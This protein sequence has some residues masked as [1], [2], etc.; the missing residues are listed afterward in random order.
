MTITTSMIMTTSTISPVRSPVRNSRSTQ[1]QDKV[2]LLIVTIR[3]PGYERRVRDKSIL[4]TLADKDRLKVS[5]K[6]IEGKE[7]EAIQK[8]DSTIRSYVKRTA[9]PSP[10]KEGVYA[11][12][13]GL[14]EAV[15]AKLQQFS[16]E[17][18]A[19]VEK[20]KE[21]WSASVEQA[22]G[23]LGNLFQVDDYNI[24]FDRAYRL[25]W[26]YVSLSAPAQIEGI[27]QELYTRE[28]ARLQKQWEEAVVEMRDALRVGLSEL[29]NDLVQRLSGADGEKRVKP[30]RLLERF[31]EFLTSFQARNVTGDEQLEAL[32]TQ[33]RQILA[34]VST[35]R[36][37]ASTNVRK[38]VEQGFKQVQVSLTKLETESRHR[39]I[40]FDDE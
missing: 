39:R 22:R 31:Q 23:K 3:G 15:D 34:G 1:I 33:A 8:L 6:L 30:S 25:E 26:Q 14:L 37:I 16:E 10:F 12:P 4:T 9:L 35:E 20:L 17:R 38:Q 18:N 5:M 7:H 36:L 13:L 11:L 32:A 28:Q 2:V 21:A 24:D 40:R 29:V 27:D 19:A